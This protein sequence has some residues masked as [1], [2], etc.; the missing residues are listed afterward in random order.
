MNPSELGFVVPRSYEG[1]K[2]GVVPLARVVDATA[3]SLPLFGA[4]FRT[5]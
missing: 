4:S 3:F 1:I 5:Q 2:L